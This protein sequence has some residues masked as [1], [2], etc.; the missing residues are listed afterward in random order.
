MGALHGLQFVWAH[1]ELARHKMETRTD[2]ACMADDDDSLDDAS[3][4]LADWAPGG[5]GDD[6]SKLTA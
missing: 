5:G 4:T 3:E 1:P 2:A 6:G